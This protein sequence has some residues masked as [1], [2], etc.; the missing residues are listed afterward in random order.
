[1]D[2]LSGLLDHGLRQDE[3]V[4][5]LRLA[6]VLGRDPGAPQAFAGVP[7]LQ[8]GQAHLG[9]EPFCVPIKTRS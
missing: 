5:R 1:M 2:T 7:L 6:Q 4:R 9:T 3:L 8:V